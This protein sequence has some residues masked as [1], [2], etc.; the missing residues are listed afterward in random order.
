[1]DCKGLCQCAFRRRWFLVSSQGRVVLK[2][3]VTDLPDEQRWSLQ[4]QLVGQWALELQ[5][6]WREV[7]HVDDTRPC[8]VE[9]I[10]VTSIDRNGEAVLAEI[11]SQ[12]AD[13][14]AS[15]VYTKHLLR[16]L[17]SELKR[18]RMKGKQDGGGND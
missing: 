18:R 3:T 17:R 4:G 13:F 7:Y 8:T 2:I 9:L 10:E 15:D 11:M 6:T 5:S 16:N 14:T 12:G 1:V